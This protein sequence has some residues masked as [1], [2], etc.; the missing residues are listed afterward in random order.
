MSVT[1][2]D[3]TNALCSDLDLLLEL[4]AVLISLWRFLEV[5]EDAALWFSD[6]GVVLLKTLALGC[7]TFFAARF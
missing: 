6:F 3:S 4:S 5:D 7:S 1:E 2:G